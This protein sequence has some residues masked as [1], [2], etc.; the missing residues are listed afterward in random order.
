MESCS[1]NSATY[2]ALR[3]QRNE[4]FSEPGSLHMSLFSLEM[5][6]MWFAH[7]EMLWTSVIS[8]DSS[9]CPVTVYR[10]THLT[11]DYNI[12]VFYFGPP[13]SSNCKSWQSHG[14]DSKGKQELMYLECSVPLDESV[15]QMHECNYCVKLVC[16]H[17]TSHHYIQIMCNLYIFPVNS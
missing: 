8:S 12:L 11:M 14:F 16:V 4:S 15:C 1:G 5:F 6:E 7:I 10:R 17:L 3:K 2:Y 9:F 13:C